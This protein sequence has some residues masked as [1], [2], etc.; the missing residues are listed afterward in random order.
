M[1]WFATNFLNGKGEIG[2][3]NASVGL[4]PID[5]RMDFQPNIE[6]LSSKKVGP[7]FVSQRVK[8]LCG[9]RESYIILVRRNDASQSRASS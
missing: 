8:L 7:L 2:V 4:A 9:G 5:G 6:E 1:Q 3:G